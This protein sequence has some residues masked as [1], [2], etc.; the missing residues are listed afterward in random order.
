MA[1]GRQNDNEMSA[2]PAAKDYTFQNKFQ[3]DFY[4]SVEGFANYTHY[5]IK[6]FAVTLLIN[7]YKGFP[8]L[9][10]EVLNMYSPP[11]VKAIESPAI[12][13][14]LQRTKFVTG[15]TRP[16]VPQYLFYK[17]STKKAKV[18]GVKERKKPKDA[19]E[20]EPHI[21]AELMTLLMWDEKT[22][23]YLK[24]GEKAQRL[25]NHLIGEDMIRLKAEME[26]AAEKARKTR[27]VQAF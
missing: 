24:W 18:E 19:V 13:K 26:K 15:F 8:H 6:L 12:M 14:A 21:K 1:T 16:R 10:D 11:F 9:A 20:F 22:Y 5:E 27:Q 4:T 7:M 17:Q 3:S 25:G 2:S 23:E